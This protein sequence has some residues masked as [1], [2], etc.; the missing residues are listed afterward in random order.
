MLEQ[1][2]H[3]VES[4]LKD[5]GRRLLQPS[6]REQLLDEIDR[7]NL[8][9]QQ[10]CAELTASQR[11]L[12][13]VKRRLRDNPTAAALMHSRIETMM[14]NGQTAQAWCAALDLDQLRHTLTT[15]GETCPRLEQRCWSLH[16]S[17]R[18]L[19]RRLDRLLEQLSPS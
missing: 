16:F 10:R 15:D 13:A 8:Q 11:E 12:A 17:L 19:Q 18:Q 6:A 2:I 3:S 1:M 5:L 7:L 4:G 9:L 14:R